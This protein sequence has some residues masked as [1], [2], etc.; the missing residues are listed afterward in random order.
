MVL[1]LRDWIYFALFVAADQITK[2]IA[3]FTQPHNPLFFLTWNTGAGFGILQN[4]NTILLLI[5][6][7]VLVLLY[8]PLTQANGYERIAYT[9]LA[10]GITGNALDRLVHGAVVDFIRIGTFPIFNVADSLIS[11]SITFFIVH[12]LLE[13]KQSKKH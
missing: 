10:A 8:K 6:L 12:A 2:L 4:K 7:A 13:W 11:L 3:L 9:A 1:A 5:A